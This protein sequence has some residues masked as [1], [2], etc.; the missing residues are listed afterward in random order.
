MAIVRAIVNGERDG[1]KLAQFRDKRCKSSEEVIAKALIGDWK[2][3]HLFA[4]KQSLALYDFYT[5]QV[6][7]CDAQIQQ[8]YSAMKP[9]WDITPDVPRQPHP[10]SHRKKS[11]I[12]RA[13]TL[14]PRSSGSSAWI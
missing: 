1:V 12:D 9:R 2:A 4:L 13:T 14:K 10:K 3:E 8:Q 5:Q 11:K 7:Q 6:T